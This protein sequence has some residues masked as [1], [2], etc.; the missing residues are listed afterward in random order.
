MTQA[1]NATKTHEGKVVSIEGDKLKTTCSKGN[2][3]CHTVA[4]DAKVTTDGKDSKATDLKSGTC[5]KVTEHT[6]DKTVATAIESGKHITMT[7]ATK[8]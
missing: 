1:A 5:V 4:K 2:E 7:P 8:A 6:D 3:H